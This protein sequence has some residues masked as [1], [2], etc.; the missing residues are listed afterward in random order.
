MARLSASARKA[1]PTAKFAGP[2]RSFPV[3]D[4]DHA[5]AAARLDGNASAATKAKV[6]A[7]LKKFV[8][9]KSK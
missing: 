8:G 3:E 6:K 7:A 2:G 9:G 4:K 5:E 1:I